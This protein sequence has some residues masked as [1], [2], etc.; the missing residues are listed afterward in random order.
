MKSN[1]KLKF[2]LS[3]SEQSRVREAS[4]ILVHLAETLALKSLEP[5]VT[6]KHREGLIICIMGEIGTKQSLNTSF[7]AD[8][9]FCEVMVCVR[10]Y[11]PDELEQKRLLL[12]LLEIITADS[13]QFFRTLY[14]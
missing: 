14:A 5:R 6:Q 11:S 9:L 2:P 3:D 8:A 13:M 10:R 1:R 7:D 4:T 12:S